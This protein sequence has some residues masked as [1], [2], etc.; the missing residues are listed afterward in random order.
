MQYFDTSRILRTHVWRESE[1]WRKLDGQIN[2]FPLI[3]FS[4]RN[5]RVGT[6]YILKNAFSWREG[7][8][9][10]YDLVELYGRVNTGCTDDDTLRIEVNTRTINAWK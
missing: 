3:L 8:N 5:G 9:L 10:T 2:S 7:D 4:L 6:L 1:P